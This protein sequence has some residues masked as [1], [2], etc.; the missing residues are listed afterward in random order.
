VKKDPG[1]TAAGVRSAPL[2]QHAVELVLL[3]NDMPWPA[4][5]AAYAFLVD[6]WG[7]DVRPPERRA[8]AVEKFERAHVVAELQKV[9]DQAALE[10]DAAPPLPGRE[11]KEKAQ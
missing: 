3:D 4:W 10:T 5:S 9:W 2:V 1:A 8:K 11:T 7:K 6:Y